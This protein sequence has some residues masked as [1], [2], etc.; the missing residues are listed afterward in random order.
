MTPLLIENG[1]L[2]DPSQSIDRV[3]RV[4]VT[5]GLIAAIN[6]DD[7]DLPPNVRRIDARGRI[8]APGLIDL[9]TELREPG[10]E[11]DETIETG[12]NAALAGGFTTILCA[13]NTYPPI[14]SPGAVEFVRQKA[15]RAR[16][17]R[18]HVIACLSRGREG[19]DMAELS[20]LA[21][22]G[23]VG[24]SDAPRPTSN[25]ALL[26]KALEYCHMLDLPIYDLPLVPELTGTGVMHEGRVS[27]ILGLQGLPTEAEDLAVT[28]DLRLAEATG[29]RLHIGP[30][31]TLQG[32]E[33]I[34]RA[35]QRGINISASV[36]PQTLSSMTDKELESFD[37][38]FKVR[39]P[40]RNERHIE[41]C[42]EA[43]IDGTIDCI[44]TGHTPRAR[45]KKVNDLDLA[46]FGMVSLETTLASI[47]TD[48]IRPGLL[49]WPDAITRL[50]TRPAEIA[51]VPGGSLKPGSPAD[52]VIIDPDIAWTVRGDAFQSR[53]NSTPWEGKQLFGQA[54]HAIVGGEVRFERHA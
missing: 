47:N 49:S 25:S 22:A 42:R 43:L 1:R 10:R 18:I 52:I 53:S 21:E 20:L 41:V 4:L 29:G 17:C 40:L 39:P 26:K 6:P 48:M 33:L 31:S 7:G 35:K 14:D 5:G 45:E 46:P 34:K 12:G 24:F 3:A 28:R 38:R 15:Q 9:G 50:S 44:S 37:A 51:G 27:T 23:A 30:I 32:V 11:E 19:V 16:T 54:T 2:V 36:W 13:A 8:V